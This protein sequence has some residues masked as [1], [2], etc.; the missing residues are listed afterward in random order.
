MPILLS[1]M[2]H[3][4]V[5]EGPESYRHLDVSNYKTGFAKLFGPSTN[6]THRAMD[7]IRFSI[8]Q[9]RRMQMIVDAG[10]NALSEQGVILGV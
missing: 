3:R 5:I 9:Q 7:D 6:A 4:G 1:N 8:G 10:V 2:D